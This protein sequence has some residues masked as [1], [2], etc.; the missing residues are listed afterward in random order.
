M[1]T[2]N[3]KQIRRIH[4]LAWEFGPS[5]WPNC[6]N[7]PHHDVY[8]VLAW[9]FTT[10]QNRKVTIWWGFSR[11]TAPA[12]MPAHIGADSLKKPHH[13]VT[14]RFSEAVKDHA[15]YRLGFNLVWIYGRRILYL[16]S[17]WCNSQL[18][19]KTDLLAYLYVLSLRLCVLC[20]GDEL[21]HGR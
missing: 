19:K 2:E 4:I 15:K 7:G 3:A 18:G 21:F 17:K 20:I 16:H 9:S 6:F 10:S 8:T 13:I 11:L 5:S 1:T 12:A 14:L